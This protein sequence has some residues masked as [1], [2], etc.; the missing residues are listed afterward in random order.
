MYDE[1]VVFKKQQSL[2]RYLIKF[3]VTGSDDNDNDNSTSSGN[4]GDWS[5]MDLSWRDCKKLILWVD[6][7]IQT[8]RSLSKLWEKNLSTFTISFLSQSALSSWLD[9][10][11]SKLLGKL[12]IISNRYRAKDGGERAPDNLKKFLRGDKRW[13]K[14]PLCFYCGNVDKVRHLKGRL[15]FVTNLSSDLEKWV[16][17]DPS[18]SLLSWFWG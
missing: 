3:K 11:G 14:I 2:P 15:T 1:L 6:P 4:D 8:S 18:E 7:N 12:K 10:F 17:E 5:S 16:K 13:R 9:A